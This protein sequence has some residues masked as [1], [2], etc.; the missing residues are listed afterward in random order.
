MLNNKL[1]KILL[2]LKDNNYVTA[3][4]ISVKLKISPK[5]VRIRIKELNRTLKDN[6]VTIK[7]KPRHGYILENKDILD[8]L[9]KNG[10]SDLNDTSANDFEYRIKFLFEYFINNLDYVKCG[11]L[12]ELLDISKTTLTGLLKILE[13]NL[14]RYN[15]KIE[16]RPNYG[17]RLT[18]SEFDF[19]NAIVEYFIRQEISSNNEISEKKDLD[20]IAKIIIDFVKKYEIRL[21]EINLENVIEH[22]YV[23]IN[24]IKNNRFVELSDKDINDIG[25]KEIRLAGKLAKKLE[26]NN[27]IFPKSE[28]IYIALHIYSKSTI[29]FEDKSD[30]NFVI[31]QKEDNLVI[32]MLDLIYNELKIDFRSN[33]DLRLL[34]NQHMIPLDIRLRYNITIKNPMLEDIKTS[35]S[36]SYLLAKEASVVLKEYYK[37]PISDDEIGYLSLIFQLGVE[38][39]NND[40]NKINILIVCGQ[41]KTTSKLLMNKYRKEFGKNIGY[42]Y[43]TDLLH[44]KYFDFSKIDYIFSTVPITIKVPVPI[45][46]IGFFLEKKDITTV[47]EALELS[48]MSFLEKYYKKDLFSYGIE[49]NTREEVIKNICDIV[50]NKQNVPKYFYESIIKREE[51][52]ET[53]FGNFIAIPHPI[54]IITKETFVYVGILKKPILWK[55]NIVQVVFLISISNKKDENLKKFYQAT[56]NFLLNEEHVKDLIKNKTFDNLIKLLKKYE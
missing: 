7:S 13:S 12:S 35:Y 9:L 52:S 23:A 8:N 36:F 20:S 24:R 50:K 34:L 48:S 18:G 41:G 21:S 30:P 38:E 17:I 16:R 55:K 28:I 51:L 15:I 25:K 33:S 47:H 10:A 14:S 49:G 27:I 11:Y 29:G 39:Q 42:I 19:R 43:T 1:K 26:S 32:K 31:R 40:I 45:F 44:L 37:K 2:L 46:N 53:D 54:E 5:T 6:G 56:T 22:I 4:T 3:K